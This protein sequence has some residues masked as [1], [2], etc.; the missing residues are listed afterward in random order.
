METQV[1]LLC[2][3]Q[4]AIGPYPEPDKSIPHSHSMFLQDPYIKIFEIYE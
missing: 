3:Q 4:S 2:S 1:S